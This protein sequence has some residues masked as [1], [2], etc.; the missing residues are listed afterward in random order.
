MRSKK[1]LSLSKAATRI[2]A[3]LARIALA[4]V[5]QANFVGNAIAASPSYGPL[6]E[7]AISGNADV[8]RKWIRDGKNPDEKYNDMGFSLES[9]YARVRGL[10]ALMV[11]AQAG[12]L[13]IV[14]ILIEGGA[15]IYAE[16]RQANGSNPSNAFDYAV[17]G[18]Q[19]AVAAYLWER[20]DK[21]R[22]TANLGSQFWSACVR[23]C[24]EKHG[25]TEA[26][27]LPLFLARITKDEEV[28]GRAIGMTACWRDALPRLKFLV[29]HGVRFPKNTLGCIASHTASSNNLM[30]LRARIEIAQ[31]L[32]D[33][34]ADPNALPKN[35]SGYSPLMLAAGS[36]D[37]DMLKFL[38][39]HGADPNLQNRDGYAPV[40]VAANICSDT[41]ATTDSSALAAAEIWQKRQLTTIETLVAAGARATADP[42]M[43]LLSKCCVRKSHT[44]TQEKIC[45]V[46]G[47]GS[48]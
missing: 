31:F 9:N 25:T 16:S 30:D 11:A 43:T 1:N 27:N 41:S 7:A 2:R 47:K 36:H 45:R 28:L 33:Q 34:G 29:R 48:R 20:S 18:G 46:F 17:E 39:A 24:D 37:P 42:K 8:V 22:F 10:T 32:L 23:L 4:L 40:M 44:D 21:V 26:D 5:M 38:L 35:S 12:Q 14:K 13:E 19:L 6:H 15:G 3:V